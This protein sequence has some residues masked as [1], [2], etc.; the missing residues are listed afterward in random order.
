MEDKKD[1]GNSI[2]RRDFLAGLATIPV[3]GV[4]LAGH[5]SK[6]DYKNQKVDEIIGGLGF[7]N[8][9][10]EGTDVA[11]DL[12]GDILRLGIIG[13]GSRGT[14]ILD[15]LGFTTNNQENFSHG[16]LKV[17]LN[18][19]CD[20]YDKHAEEGMRLSEFNR[21]GK[22]KKFS[23]KA[24]RYSHYRDM[25]ESNDID[26]VIISTP[27]HWHAQMIIDAVKAGKHVY[28]EKCMTRTIVEAYKVRDVLSGSDIVFQ[29]GHQ[30]RQQDSYEVARK[31]IEKGIL[32]KISVIKTHTNR[33][34]ERQAWIRHIGEKINAN[35]VDWKQ[36][37][38]TVPYTPFTADR[39][40]GWQKFFEYSGGLPAH[41]FSHEYDALNQVLDIG[42]PKSVVAMGGTYYWKDT[43]N[44][45]DVFQ[46]IFEYPDKELLLTY[47]A[48]LSS[49]SSGH[50]ESGAKVKELYGSDAWMRLAM[51]IDVIVDRYSKRYKDK[52]DAGIIE[53]N[54]P[55]L[56]Y[57]P[58]KKSNNLDAISSASEKFYANQGLVYTYK[59][60]KKVDVTYLHL[61][62]WIDAIR[63]GGTPRGTIKTAF[64]DAITCLMATKSYQEKRRVEWDPVNEKVI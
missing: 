57:S 12:D 56:S 22:E 5:L 8:I 27:D 44:T 21:Y 18:G 62:E 25:L 11:K 23:Q 53:P 46:A 58:M 60:G 31:M 64:E 3:L 20:V 24:K 51:N 26:A 30:N 43:R 45:P 61:R 13:I 6:L 38:G 17:V 33:N 40:F 19:V 4:F 14:T 7:D 52:L 49:S 59:N 32:G 39:Y 35:E 47:D 9:G 54:I 55:F 50:Y 42:I 16:D 10:E 28:S 15:S 63:N 2:N 34:K 1:K 48:T 29:Y 36:W 37:L 41:M